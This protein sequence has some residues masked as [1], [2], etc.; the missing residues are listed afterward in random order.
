VQA[1]LSQRFAAAG[2]LSD[3]EAPARRRELIA[4]WVADLRRRTTVVILPQ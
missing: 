2:A 3:P 1:Y 4:D